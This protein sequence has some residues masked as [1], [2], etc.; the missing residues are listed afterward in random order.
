[1]EYSIVNIS[2]T[3]KIV[4]YTDDLKFINSSIYNWEAVMKYIFDIKCARISPKSWIKILG[5]ISDII[6]SQ[7]YWILFVLLPIFYKIMTNILQKNIFFSSFVLH[8]EDYRL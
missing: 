3:L 8:F 6:T 4:L 5:M 1:M 2:K 7:M